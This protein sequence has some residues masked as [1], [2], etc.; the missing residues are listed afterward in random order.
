MTAFKE[1]DP[2]QIHGQHDEDWRF[3]RRQLNGQIEAYRVKRNGGKDFRVFDESKV[4]AKPT[5]QKQ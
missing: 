1:N 2:L 3:Y 5:V 4:S